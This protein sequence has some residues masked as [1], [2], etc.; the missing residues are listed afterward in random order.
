MLLYARGG[1]PTARGPDP[2]PPRKGLR[3]TAPS[4]NCSNCMA[5]L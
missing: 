4:P 1:Q 2:A 3:P 5:H